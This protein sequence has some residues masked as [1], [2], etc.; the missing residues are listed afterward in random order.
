MGLLRRSPRPLS[1][2]PELRP[3]RS[4]WWWALPAS[5]LVG[6]AVWSTGAWLLQGLDTVPA[7]EQISARIEAVRTALAAGAGVGAAVTL[8]LAVRRQRHQELTAAHGTHDAAERRVTE[9]Y[10]KAAEQLGNAQAPVRLAGLY[11]LERLAQDTPVL[12]Q[13]IVDV[14]CAYLRM[15]YTPPRE[16][17][18][19]K[20]RAAQRAARARE[21]A[22][23]GTSGGRD[24]QEER[25]VRLTAQ[26][27]LTAHLRYDDS[28]A[29]RRRWP[30]RRLD[31]NPRHWPAI[32]LDLT[33]AVLIDFD[34]S[35]CR[36]DTVEFTR[37]AFT[38]DA[39]FDR[40]VFAGGARF[41]GATFS[42]YAGFE[43]AAFKSGARFDGTAFAGEAQFGGAAF[44]RYARFGGA[45]FAGS[46]GFDRATFAGGARFDR[47]T[48]AGS[49]R[50]DRATF[51]GGAR[52][53]RATFSRHARFD[54]TTFVGGARFDRATF[55][56]GAGFG[57]ATFTGDNR[58]GGA[59]GL[60]HA[61]LRD[62][63]VGPVTVEAKRQ[64]PPTWREEPGTDGWRTLRLG[65][66]PPAGP[67]D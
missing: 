19:E 33:G 65:A 46:V 11:A 26:R 55:N 10:T 43:E 14:I 7:A 41:G 53:D 35:A 38:G 23:P 29:P 48:F 9:L 40:A 20:I 22:R 61:E 17:R 66:E 59:T 45:T 30:S 24:P 13:T 1:R 50:F 15:P 47:A 4:M 2:P 39:R 63:R 60:E 6:V 52:F 5:L 51:V 42:R 62:V 16:D 56:A 31:R 54:A 64:W 8:L 28:P 49:V 21:P 57:E 67:Q 32:R 27:V 58:F 25:Q 44:S 37:T 18:A 36:V 34:L 3:P 12:R